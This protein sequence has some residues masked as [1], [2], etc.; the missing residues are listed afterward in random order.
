MAN[1]ADSPAH[2][3]PHSPAYQH[4][5][6][7]DL[8]ADSPPAS[9]ASSGVSNSSS[10]EDAG[11]P[12]YSPAYGEWPGGGEPVYV[13]GSPGPPSPPY[14]P[15]GPGYSPTSPWTAPWTAPTA[16]HTSGAAPHTT[17]A[18]GQAGTGAY[19][20]VACWNN[21]PN[22]LMTPCMH[23]SLCDGC[24]PKA[25]WQINGCPMCRAFVDRVLGPVFLP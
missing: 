12:P 10:S 15:I 25:N 3:Q 8:T 19:K 4:L 11:S 9:P 13:P 2:Q 17:S 20:C 1:N 7:I 21:P 5:G 6:L 22:M 24:L 18:A 16:P 14:H 23:L